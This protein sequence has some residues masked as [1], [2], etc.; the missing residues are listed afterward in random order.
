MKSPTE[1][2]S[3]NRILSPSVE[4]FWMNFLTGILV[5]GSV[6][7]AGTWVLSKIAGF[8]FSVS[9]AAV[10]FLSL[11]IVLRSVKANRQPKTGE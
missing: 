1:T 3:S 4:Q 6:I 5:A 10:V 11:A 7:L 2:Q 9:G 8:E